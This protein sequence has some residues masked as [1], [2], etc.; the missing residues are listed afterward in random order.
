LEPSLGAILFRPRGI[1]QMVREWWDYEDASLNSG[2]EYDQKALWE[3]L[4]VNDQKKYSLNKLHVAMTSEPIFPG[5]IVVIVSYSLPNA[6]CLAITR[7]D[8]NS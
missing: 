4:S 5:N 8:E 7:V 3:I 1:E 2:G 6:S